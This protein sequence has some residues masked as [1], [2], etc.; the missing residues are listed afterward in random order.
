M[1]LSRRGRKN[2]ELFW[3]DLDG[4]SP[5]WVPQTVAA[6]SV[7]GTATAEFDQLAGRLQAV[8]DRLLLI[9]GG[10][11]DRPEII[12]SAGGDTR[13]FDAAR[14][15]VDSAP[16]E[17]ASRYD[18]RALR[19]RHPDP[20]GLVIGF[21]GTKLDPHTVRWQGQ[22][23]RNNPTVADLTV[24]VP[25]FIDALPAAGT[26]N[27]Q[28]CGAVFLLLDH[29]LG[30]WAVEMQV[31]GIDWAGTDQLPDSARPLIELADWLDRL[32]AG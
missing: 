29:L 28:R 31:G 4:K 21:G 22:V 9:I 18:L 14:A 2:L 24:Y 30:E 8:D 3:Q 11:P 10:S 27:E 32:S 16:A 19:P 5:S 26:V 13:A 15:V 7:D 20:A 6:M 1:T 17:L 25:G 23:Q 12:I